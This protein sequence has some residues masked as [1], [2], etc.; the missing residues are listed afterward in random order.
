[1]AYLRSLRFL[2]AMPTL[3]TLGYVG[4]DTRT[5][6]RPPRPDSE[7]A[8]SHPAPEEV[9]VDWSDLDVSLDDMRAELERRGVDVN[10]RWSRATLMKHLEDG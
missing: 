7:A 2:G 9:T 5:V 8:P 4:I 1:M 10:K 6:A 3:K